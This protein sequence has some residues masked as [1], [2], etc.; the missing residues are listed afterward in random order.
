M[1]PKER[2]A[3]MLPFHPLRE[4][5]LKTVIYYLPSSEQ[6]FDCQSREQIWFTTLLIVFISKI[7]SVR[8]SNASKNIKL[9]QTVFEHETD[10][11]K[12]QWLLY[13][14]FFLQYLCEFP[15]IYSVLNFYP[16]TISTH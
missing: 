10:V 11:R 2:P 14:V 9:A 6:S 8:R 7:T 5:G 3:F 13:L 1:Q 12:V 4:I 15:G 16:K